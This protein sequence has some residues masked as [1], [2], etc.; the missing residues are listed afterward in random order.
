MIPVSSATPQPH[1]IHTV[2]T[3]KK[4][5]TVDTA[6]L[7]PS[8]ILVFRDI[9]PLTPG[10]R[11]FR[12]MSGS[13]TRH[14]MSDEHLKV[15][16]VVIGSG[17]GGYVA[18]IKL[19]Q[20]G[21]KTLVV[22]SDPNVGGVCL[23]RG[24]IPS[25]ALIAAAHRY[26]VAN[27][28]AMG[29][30]A[31]ASVD[32]PA[33]QAWKED[34]VH[35]L[36]QGVASLLKT[37]GV[38]VIHGSATFTTT[39]RLRVVVPDGEDLAVEFRHAIIATGSVPVQIPGFE[40]DGE[41]IL[42]S[43]EALELRK[44]PGRLLVIGGGYIGLELGTAWAKLGARVTVVEMER[45]LL[46]GFPRDI[47][48]LVTR[49]LKQL[50]VQVHTQTRATSWETGDEG[51]LMVKV[52]PEGKSSMTLEVDRVL[53]TVGR[54]PDADALNPAAAGVRLDPRGFIPVDERLRTNVQHIL[55]IGDIT[56]E[57]MLAHKAS[58]Q[59]EVAARVIAGQEARFEPMAIP[60]V[61]FTDPEIASV[62]LSQAR[63][64]VRGL[65]VKV[66][67]F[68]FLANGRA[69]TTGT[70]EGFVR[71]VAD[72][73]TERILGVEII[74]PEA[75]NLISEAAVAV[76]RGLTLE[77]LGETIHPHPTLSEALMEA[78]KAARGEAIHA[79]NR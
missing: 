39:H 13:K 50:G 19:G 22:E 17:P 77:E 44:V 26:E 1:P 16:T 78:A 56:G 33:L 75:S 68:P 36:R 79:L 28:E 46:P 52:E 4:T 45:Q 49:K 8:F 10:R 32:V 69:L 76:E 37:N 30:S 34:V 41:C 18:A 2:S 12:S 31:T 54:R 58:A 15:D 63:A 53:V 35:K 57:P 62:G 61:V 48:S 38:E 74:G 6:V 65:E 21:V 24:C 51:G 71:V 66:G 60:A 55:A 11:R 59:A 27:G 67:K 70:A 47:V 7:R 25:K 9:E 23:N 42:S 40:Y 14:A 43:T 5:R 20:L 64:R 3:L 72:D 29:V 73:K